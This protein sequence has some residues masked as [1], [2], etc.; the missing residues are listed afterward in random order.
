MRRLP[1]WSELALAAAC[2]LAAAQ[3]A[4]AAAARPGAL[5]DSVLLRISGREDITRRRFERAV[6]LLGG[7]PDS[8]TPAARDQFLELVLEQRLLAARA[9]RDP[10]P[11]TR[12]DSMQF[13]GERDNILVRA[14]LSDQL[15]R[16][17]AKRRAAGQ[18]DLDM[19]SLGMAARESLMVELAPKFD[20]SLLRSVGSY[21][22]ELPQAT[23]DMTPRQQLELAMQMPK[24]PAAD[25]LKVL[26]RSSLGDFTVADLLDDWRR[27]SS[28]YRPRIADSE[29]LKAVV[30]N[31]LF[32][33]II[34]KAADDPRM[35]ERPL[36]AAT[37]ADRA[38][39]H[40]VS[41]FLSREVVNTVPTDSLTLL[42][43]W[44][45]RRG[46]FLQPERAVLVLVTLGDSLAAD[47]MARRFTVP[48]EAESLAFRAQRSGLRYTYVATPELD[49]TV[50]GR[51]KR[52][53]AG[54]VFG[55]I[56]VEGGWQL[57]KVLSLEAAR[58]KDF[59]EAR[60]A[61]LRSWIDAET[62]RRI[63]ALLDQLKREAKLE[64]N[65]AALR[66]IVLPPARARR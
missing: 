1:R 23:P 14:A 56:R 25:T 32:E 35:L 8:L 61:V 44:R 65:E 20:E 55:P 64:R 30:E 10:K 48:G 11:W 47:S 22:A 46:D 9:L 34:R 4:R 53:G 66:A 52:T 50:Y 49:S 57:F 45:A 37:I 24:V 19:Q 59:R 54:G 31:S 41:Q 2:L 26:A 17:E 3:P 6:R 40:A 43:H 5:P 29:A 38:E 28:V 13:R 58:Q 12:A 18:P 60:E 51:A 63:R 36:V 7:S 15:Q 39:Y 33:R 62:E 16:I 42:A 27:L 21:F